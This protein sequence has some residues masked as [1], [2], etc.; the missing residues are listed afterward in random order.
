MRAIIQKRT[1]VFWFYNT[2][3]LWLLSLIDFRRQWINGV[4]P[5]ISHKRSCVRS[6]WISNPSHPTLFE[7]ATPTNALT[8]TQRM[9]SFVFSSCSYDFSARGTTS[10]QLQK[11]RIAPCA[12]DFLTFN[13]NT[14]AYEWND[15][16]VLKL[17]DLWVFSAI[18]TWGHVEL[19]FSVAHWTSR[20]DS[21]T[22]GP[23]S[24]KTNLL[25]HCTRTSSMMRLCF[26]FWMSMNQWSYGSE[27]LIIS[28]FSNMFVSLMRLIFEEPLENG[29]LR[30]RTTSNS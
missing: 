3:I 23:V 17:K 2:C 19:C 4:G 24:K 8:I 27:S 12:V 15:T 26:D 25:M 10:L 16:G 1:L 14:K 13:V 18:D 9:E 11:S 7:K 6:I 22:R 30:L 21:I 28:K 29:E 20:W 5:S